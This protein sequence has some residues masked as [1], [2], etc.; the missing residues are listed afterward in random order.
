MMCLLSFTLLYLQMKGCKDFNKFSHQSRLLTIQLDHA[1]V[2]LLDCSQLLTIKMVDLCV[3]V[4]MKVVD[5]DL[6]FHLPLK[7][8]NFD[9][10]S[11]SYGQI[12]GRRSDLG[13]TTISA[14]QQNLSF[15]EVEL[16]FSFNIKVVRLFLSFPSI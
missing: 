8:A 6:S 16:G 13:K 3:L 5:L 14:S 7:S 11:S 9:I 10:C 2:T 12:S 1:V 4:F 15:L